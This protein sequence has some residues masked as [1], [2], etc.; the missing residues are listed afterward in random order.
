MNTKKIEAC[1]ASA[2]KLIYDDVKKEVKT[3]NVIALVFRAYDVQMYKVASFLK[4]LAGIH[5]MV[6]VLDTYLEGLV[7]FSLINKVQEMTYTSSFYPCSHALYQTF[8]SIQ[9]QPEK[10]IFTFY[11]ENEKSEGLLLLENDA[12][13]FLYLNCFIQLHQY[14]QWKTG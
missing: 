6:M 4:A 9:Q 10:I 12:P 13:F 11:Q 8:R 2:E 5:E 3:P 1:F 14:H 7:R